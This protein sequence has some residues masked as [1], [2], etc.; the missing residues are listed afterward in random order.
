MKK[1]QQAKYKLV[2]NRRNKPLE[3]NEKA[4]VEL[5]VYFSRT[6]R[7]FITTKVV[8]EEAHWGKSGRYMDLVK[9]THPNYLEFNQYLTGLL[10][11]LQGYEYSLIND[12]RPFNKRI[13]EDY[14]NNQN[15]VTD[16]IAF[17]KDEA[18]GDNSIV[19]GTRKEWN[20]TINIFQEYCGQRGCLFSEFNYDKVIGFDK[21]LRGKRLKQ[22]T[23]HKHHKNLLRFVNIAV[24]K[25][26]LKIENNPYND[27]SSKKIP[28]T[29]ENLTLAQ[30]HKIENITFPDY[31]FDQIRYVRDLFLFSVYTGMRY[32]DVMDLK[33]SNVEYSEDGLIIRFKQK[34]VEYAKGIDVVLP[35]YLLFDGKP[36]MLLLKFL[37]KKT[38]KTRVFQN[39]TNQ[40][41]NRHLKS[42]GLTAR[43]NVPISF[44]VARHTFGTLLSDIT[45]NPYLIMQLMGH[46]DIKTSMIYIHQ[47]EERLRRQLRNVNW[48]KMGEVINA[49]SG[50]L[51]MESL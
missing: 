16:F 19:A 28:G 50:G 44:H 30:V 12:G 46:S 1:L 7:K 24:R 33:H 31:G 6:E 36:E 45:G 49:P 22:N 47:S 5:E 23:I 39:I 29:R 48:N 21:M 26:Y 32:S 20:Y 13:L 51:L 9:S 40:V 17:L 35:L 4:A 38:S 15:T 8:I 41:V 25:R 43:V 11:E 14:L 34:K 27:F 37:E 3:K 18:D 10:N 2:F 42:I